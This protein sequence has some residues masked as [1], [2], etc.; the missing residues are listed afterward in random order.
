MLGMLTNLVTFIYY[1][2]VAY[3]S[4]ILIYGFVKS[5]SWEKEILYVVVLVPFLLR[6]FMLK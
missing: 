5:K 4:V 1:A 2:L 3:V 6:L